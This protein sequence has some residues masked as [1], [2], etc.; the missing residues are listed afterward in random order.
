MNRG[1]GRSKQCKAH[2]GNTHDRCNADANPDGG[3][4][5][6]EIPGIVGGREQPRQ[7]QCHCVVLL[8][9]G[10]DRC[11]GKAAHANGNGQSQHAAQSESQRG[12]SV[13]I[14]FLKRLDRMLSAPTPG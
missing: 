11:K 7:A 8:H 13:H 12:Q 6:H 4:R 5:T 3:Q 10:Q 9:H 2:E 1:H 14:S